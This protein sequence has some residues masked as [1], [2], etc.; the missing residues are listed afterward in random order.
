MKKYFYTLHWFR[1]PK[2]ISDALNYV[3]DKQIE[4]L[5]D[6]RAIDLLINIENVARRD[7]EKYKLSNGQD[8]RGL[9]Y[10]A[11]KEV[12]EQSYNN[13]VRD[14]FDILNRLTEKDEKLFS[15]IGY[16]LKW[17]SPF[18]VEGENEDEIYDKVQSYNPNYQ[19]IKIDK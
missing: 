9:T 13:I 1:T 2:H 18:E 8:I 15:E 17:H 5:D 16:E 12:S 10:Y 7:S 4:M 3:R 19:L 11:Y 6:T 14:E